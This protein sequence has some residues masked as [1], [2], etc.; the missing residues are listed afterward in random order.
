M[1]NTI[2]IVAWIYFSL[3]TISIISLPIEY[4]LNKKLVIPTAVIIMILN[5]VPIYIIANEYK[6]IDNYEDTKNAKNRSYMSFG[7]I[8]IIYGICLFFIYKKMNSN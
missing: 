1:T 8:P 4:L 7:M 3:F 5:S 2:L 6:K